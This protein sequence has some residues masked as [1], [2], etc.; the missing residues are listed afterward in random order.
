[1]S[2]LPTSAPAAR[3]PEPARLAT[4]I[5]LWAGPIGLGLAVLT[6]IA[7]A[8]FFR[9]GPGTPTAGDSRAW[10]AIWIAMGLAGAGC[11]AGCVANAVWLADAWRR[12][13]RP[14]AIEWFRA[15]LGILLGVA[16][17]AIWFS[18]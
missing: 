13:H 15:A 5:V 11:V 17:A 7:A 1:M 14:R 9:H 8:P 4:T 10:T 2:T 16:G 3:R 6:L 12:T 18:G